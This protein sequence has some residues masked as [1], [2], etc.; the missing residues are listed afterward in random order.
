MTQ[1]ASPE[2]TA[3][4]ARSLEVA[5]R[6]SAVVLELT[7]VDVFD[8][9]PSMKRIR[10]SGDGLS[11]FTYEPGQDLMLAVA[12]DADTVVR[13]RY[14]IRDLN[15]AD[16]TVD[17]DFAMHGD[18]PAMRWASTAKP[19]VTI[20]AIGPR[21]KV[22]LATDVTWHL[23]AGDD[24][25]V[26]ATLSMAG[27]APSGE[28]VYIYLEVGG[29]AD[30]QDLSSN[31]DVIELEWIHRNGQAPGRSRGLVDKIASIDIP[32]GRGFVYLGGE[33]KIVG[34]L[35]RILVEK[36]LD[37]TMISPKAYW[38]LGAANAN[39]GEPPRE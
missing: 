34:E 10:L 13:R 36:G 3:A 7:V 27:S 38:R 8:V 25:F 18:G 33:H 31:A 23:F 24:A 22:P 17:L 2:Q 30:E 32:S 5:E 37:S 14:T 11:G 21:G 29:P 1:T 6:A 16:Q 28:A 19:G 15:V 12:S 20:E 39:H 35:R 4:R 26:P 9:T